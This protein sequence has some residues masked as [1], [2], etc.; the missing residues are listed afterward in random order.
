MNDF[1]IGNREGRTVTW[2]VIMLK[3]GER[4]RETG[5]PLPAWSNSR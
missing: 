3:G 5:T 1:I 4:E 2:N